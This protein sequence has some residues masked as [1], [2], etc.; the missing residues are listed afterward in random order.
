MQVEKGIQMPA[1]RR[2]S[3]YGNLL[4]KMEVSDSVFCPSKKNR[5]SLLQAGYKRK[6]KF[7]TKS[8]VKDGVQGYRVWRA[9]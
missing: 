1:S 3:V 5:D 4:D 7:I 6:F 2:E 8:D 9:S